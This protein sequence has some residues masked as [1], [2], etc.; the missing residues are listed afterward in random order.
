[1]INIDEVISKYVDSPKLFEKAVEDV[2]IFGVRV[3]ASKREDIL[4]EIVKILLSNRKA[5]IVTLN[6]Q[7]LDRALRD[8]EYLNIIRTAD[9]VVP[10]GEGVVWASKILTG[11]KLHKTPGVELIED[12]SRVVTSLN[13]SIFLLGGK[14][15]VAKLAG[16]RLNEKYGV[17]I[18]GSYH[19]F[20]DIEEEE[21]IVQIINSTKADVLFV[22]MGVPKQEKFIMKYWDSL[23][24]KIAMG[25]G[26]SFDVIS[27]VKKRAPKTIIDLKLEW[28][29]RIF[30]D[31]LKKWKVP[32]ELLHFAYR[33]LREKMR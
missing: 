14:E 15:G 11:K 8:K 24:V 28:L 4:H 19:G 32:F 22:G 18:S 12:I 17:K 2:E 7:I 16:K 27:G 23:K 29:Y 9:L 33:V 20:F 10:D 25:V 21:R 31:P 3:L 13:R 30:Q 6:A 5:F 1:M 26:G